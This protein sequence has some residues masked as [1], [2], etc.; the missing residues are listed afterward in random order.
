MLKNVFIHI[1]LWLL[2]SLLPEAASNSHGS[3]VSH[4]PYSG[5]SVFH[6][7]T[8]DKSYTSKPNLSHRDGSNANLSSSKGDEQESASSALKAVRPSMSKPKSSRCSGS[9]ANLS[10]CDSEGDEDDSATR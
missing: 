5:Q 10:S 6:P 4:R 2:F 1:S 8:A 9:N 7:D 3:N